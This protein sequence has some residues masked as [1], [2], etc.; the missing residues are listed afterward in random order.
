MHPQNTSRDRICK[1]CGKHFLARWPSE[2]RS[3]CSRTCSDP[4][5]K[6]PPAKFK[7]TV[8]PG[9]GKSVTRPDWKRKYPDVYCS[10]ECASRLRAR[11]VK[12]PAHPL[13]KPKIAC[14]CRV[15][16]T[17]VMVKPSLADRFRVCSARCRG[18]WSQ[19]FVD[20]VSSLE[21]TMGNLFRAAGLAYS[22]QHY[23]G[24]YIVDFAFRD[25]RVAVECDGS[26]WH[27]LPGKAAKDRQKD[28]YLR[29]HRWTVVRLPEDDI[30]TD[31]ERCLERVRAAI[32]DRQAIEPGG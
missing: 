32:S 18:V 12:G 31:P 25:A 9:C 28:G 15:C 21:R 7:T 8:C 11:T 27:A 23:I 4:A 24:P 19:Q 6:V 30:R 29:K 17:V 20:R 10:M 2:K 5:Q 13:W 22:P 16:G 14:T 3:Y 26:Y 1:G